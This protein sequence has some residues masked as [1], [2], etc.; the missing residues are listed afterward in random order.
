MIGVLTRAILRNLDNL[1]II[2]IRFYNIE[3]GSWVI[4][5]IK[6]LSVQLCWRSRFLE[7]A[8]VCIRGNKMFV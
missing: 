4:T 2:A 3:C 6:C 7:G 5:K 1:S 8:A